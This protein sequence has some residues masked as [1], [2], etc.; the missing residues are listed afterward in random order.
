LK[1][2]WLKDKVIKMKEDWNKEKKKK[3]NKQGR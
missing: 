3:K 1:R 2:L